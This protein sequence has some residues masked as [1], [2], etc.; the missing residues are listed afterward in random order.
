LAPKETQTIRFTLDRSAF[1][2]YSIAK[3]DWVLEPGQFEILVGTS[4]RDIRLKTVVN[5]GK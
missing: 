5:V 2:Y 3:K 4:S 1:A